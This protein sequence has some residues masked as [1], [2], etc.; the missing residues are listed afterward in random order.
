MSHARVCVRVFVC[1]CVCDRYHKEDLDGAYL[2]PAFKQEF[3]MDVMFGEALETTTDAEGRE[4]EV[5][6]AV[7]VCERESVCGCVG[8]FVLVCV[9]VLISIS[10]VCICALGGRAGYH[11]GRVLGPCVPQMQEARARRLQTASDQEEEEEEG[12]CIHGG[13]CG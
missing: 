13:G 3:F 6:N 4:T 10:L 11:H 8:V 9:Y 1:V 5:K 12:Q 2:D 7:C